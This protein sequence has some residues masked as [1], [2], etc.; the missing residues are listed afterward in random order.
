M[1]YPSKIVLLGIAALLFGSILAVPLFQFNRPT[2]QP[3]FERPFITV[4]VPYAYLSVPQYSIASGLRDNSTL[5]AIINSVFVVNITNYSNTSLCI[6]GISVYAADSINTTN[7]RF[8]FS[9]TL[10]GNF[11][12]ENLGFNPYSGDIR[13]SSRNLAPHES[14]LI[15]LSGNTEAGNASALKSGV[16]FLGAKIDCS[17][18]DWHSTWGGSKQV[19][20]QNS[21]NEFLYNDLI[22]SSQTLRIQGSYVY[23]K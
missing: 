12:T 1:R 2:S 18:G 20:V 23:I 16:F 7:T 8:E 9:Q 19:Q 13:E 14:T 11:L 6:N 15:A 10:V 4:D 3:S 17:V 5:C 22:S 21:G